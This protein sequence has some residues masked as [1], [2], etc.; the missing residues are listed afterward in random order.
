VAF[1]DD[2]W[3]ERLSSPFKQT[4][5]A[6]YHPAPSLDDDPRAVNEG[7]DD[8]KDAW[9][10]TVTI[11][12]PSELL[13]STLAP[14]DEV[15]VGADWEMYF[16]AAMWVHPGHRGKDVGRE[17]V[18]A[19]LEWARTNVDPKFSG[20]QEGKE[21]VVLL[22]VYNSNASGRALYSK[23]GFGDLV[24]VPVEDGQRWMSVKV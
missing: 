9:I 22:L 12:G 5:I 8:G 11:L 7:E 10:G 15:R 14:L 13:P 4:F 17:L 6:S 23:M 1:T 19:S 20:E 18:M 16:L 3:K 24:G 2:V 21:K